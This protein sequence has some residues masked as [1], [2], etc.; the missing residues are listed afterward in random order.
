MHKGLVETD[1]NVVQAGAVLFL[2]G[3]GKA[4]VGC[5]SVAALLRDY[6]AIAWSTSSSKRVT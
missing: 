1:R 2:G 5:Y 4:G 3:S 6:A